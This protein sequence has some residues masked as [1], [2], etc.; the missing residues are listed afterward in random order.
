MEGCHEQYDVIFAGP[1]YP[2]PNLGEIPDILFQYDLIEGA[3]W[4]ILEHNPDHNFEKHP[5]FYR[6]KTY[7]TTTFAIF[8]N[9]GKGAAEEE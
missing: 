3:G 1:P 4:F 8:T 7:G 5:N 2:L 9:A 6:S